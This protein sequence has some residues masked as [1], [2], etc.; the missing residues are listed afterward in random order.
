MKKI[1]SALLVLS[2]LFVTACS[3]SGLPEPPVVETPMLTSKPTPVVAEPENT[4]DIEL[5]DVETPMPTSKPTPAV[6]EPENTSDIELR[7]VETPMPTSR[8]A[9]VVAEPENTSDAELNNAREALF[10]QIRNNPGI[11][12]ALIMEDGDMQFEHSIYFKPEKLNINSCTK[13]VMSILIGIAIDKGYIESVDTKIITYF[14][15]LEHDQD[16]RK[17]EIT[18][19]HLLTFTA[20]FDWPEWGERFGFVD[21]LIYSKNWVDF[22]L[23]RPMASTPGKQSAYNTGASHLLS[24]ILQKASGVTTSSFAT[25]HL[26]SPLGIEDVFWPQDPQG[27][28]Y[29]GLGMKMY[30]ADAMKIGLLYLHNG[31]Y[32]G[33]QIVSEDWVKESTKRHS[34]IV[35]GNRGY[36]FHWWVEDKT[37][38]PY[39]YALGAG[40]QFILIV[41]EANTVAVFISSLYMGNDYDLPR[42]YFEA[43]IT[44]GDGSAV[45]RR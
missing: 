39:Y 16:S 26:F 1:I 36:G 20:G 8:P 43:F 12:V 23:N 2:M 13:S 18:I 6:A 5:K 30:P 10:E 21:H 31:K 37:D 25:E 45:F 4:S 40:G 7:D 34:R 19:R 15:E 17:R 22:I 41:P 3:N 11:Q 24:A 32:D 27:I 28:A 38:I 33:K 14:P 9:P 29:G 35:Q 44:Q 42:R